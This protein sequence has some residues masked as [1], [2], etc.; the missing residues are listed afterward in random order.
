MVCVLKE[1][2]NAVHVHTI[3]F[4][5][6]VNPVCGNSILYVTRI[7]PGGEVQL[8]IRHLGHGLCTIWSLNSHKNLWCN[9]GSA[10][11]YFITLFPLIRKLVSFSPELI[12][13]VCIHTEPTESLCKNSPGKLDNGSELRCLFVCIDKAGVWVPRSGEWGEWPE[14]DAVSNHWI[15]KDLKA[16]R[17]EGKKCLSSSNFL[18]LLWWCRIL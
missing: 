4:S 14:E 2:W 12:I 6:S 1:A 5:S 13:C 8:Q 7:V 9:G 3:F 10:R 18:L 11:N 17:C 15:T 16:L